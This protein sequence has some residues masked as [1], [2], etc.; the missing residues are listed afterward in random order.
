M[1]KVRRWVTHRRWQ[2]TVT[3]Y[4]TSSQ[5]NTQ[6][7]I[8]MNRCYEYESPELYLIEFEVEK[9]FANSLEDPFEDN[10]MDW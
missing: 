3:Y 6:N 8:A 9:G 4:A 1:S 5:N 7:Y 10:E 2:Y